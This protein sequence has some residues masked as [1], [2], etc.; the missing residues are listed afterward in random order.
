V[1]LSQCGRYRFALWRRWGAG[2]QVLFV[3]LNPSTADAQNDDPTIRRCVGFARAWGFGSL[4]VGNL[5]AFRPTS[6]AALQRAVDP[7]GP[8]ND[9]WLVRL[10][11]ESS[12]TVAAWGNHGRLLGRSAAVSRLLPDVRI[13]GR[14]KAGEPRHPLYV[15]GNA[16]PI[17]WPTSA[18]CPAGSGPLMSPRG[19][20]GGPSTSRF[21][22]TRPSL[23]AIST[24]HRNAANH[25]AIVAP[26][27][28]R[29]I[30]PRRATD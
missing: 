20:S 19:S 12:L 23:R 17:H 30:R 10:N 15:Q 24:I 1:I 18:S 29:P 6:P 13:L 9:E 7:V 2:T 3:M 27:N 21:Q 8:G 16:E 28:P 14:T 5:F 11:D 26:A 25:R 22:L 4:V